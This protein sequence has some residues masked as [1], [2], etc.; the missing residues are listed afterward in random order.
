MDCAG[1]LWVTNTDHPQNSKVAPQSLACESCNERLGINDAN[2]GGARLYK[3]NLS[4]RTGKDAVWQTL[5]V[6]EIVCAKL[7]A[8]IDGQAI[9]KFLTYSGNIEDAPEALMVRHISD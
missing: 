5:P 6:Q 7:L 9:Y 1:K 8:L 3:W 2:S 4:L